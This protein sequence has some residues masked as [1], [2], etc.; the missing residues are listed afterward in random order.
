MSEECPQRRFRTLFISDVHLGA[1][2]RKPTDCWIS[3]AAMMPTPSTWS[4]ISSTAGAAIRLV[5]AAIAQRLRAENAA[6][7]A[8]G[9]KVIYVPGNHDE[10]LRNYYGTHFGGIDVVEDTIHEAPT[11]A[12][13]VIHGDIFDLV[14][15]NARWLAHLG[16]KAYDSPSG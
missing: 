6:Q 4:A 2:A 7:G 8:Q 5:L 13:L 14:V 3:S 9:A 12:L 11:A 16:D 1:A 15:Q 10:F